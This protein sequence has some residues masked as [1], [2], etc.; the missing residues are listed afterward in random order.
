M[1]LREPEKT[2]YTCRYYVNVTEG[3]GATEITCSHPR[4]GENKFR[5]TCF[6]CG[7]VEPE[8]VMWDKCSRCFTSVSYKERKFRLPNGLTPTCEDWGEPE[9]NLVELREAIRDLQGVIRE[10][11]AETV[12]G[13]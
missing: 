6:H 11:K 4:Y 1:R 8:L 7:K 9:P 5:T 12:K 13:E 2:C 3:Y 10:M